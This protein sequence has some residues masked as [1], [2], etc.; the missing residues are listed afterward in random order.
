MLSAAY[1]EAAKIGNV[2]RRCPRE[3][4]DEHL[5]IDDGSTDDTVAV[6]RAAGAR[7]VSLGHVA[8]VGAAI[9]CGFNIARDEG[10]D[11]VTLV[12]GNGKDDPTEVARLLDPICD[13]GFD[14]V[15]GSR[16]L[17]GGGYGGDM[18]T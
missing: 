2:V 16:F 1:N 14:F 13:Q 8:G 7:V 5:V 18:P 10:F 15:I 4:V 9:R 17:P 3:V 12:A 11:I 6:A